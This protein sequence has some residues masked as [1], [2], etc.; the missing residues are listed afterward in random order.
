MSAARGPSMLRIDRFALSIGANVLLA[1]TLVMSRL[2]P[3]TSAPD[4]AAVSASSARGG[5]RLAAIVRH[6]KPANGLSAGQPEWT[7]W[8]GA[9]RASGVS[10]DALATLLTADFDRRWSIYQRS[11]QDR[12]DAGEIDAG[13]MRRRLAQHDREQERELQQALG[14]AEFRAWKKGTLLRDFV[15]AHVTLTAE[16]SDRIF[17]AR[18]ALESNRRALEDAHDDG[19]I[20]T[21]TLAD[22][23]AALGTECAATVNAILGAARVAELSG[24]RDGVDAQARQTLGKFNLSS[25]DLNALADTQRARNTL[26]DQLEKEYVSDPSY[27]ARQLAVDAARDA[28]Y[29]SV[30]GSAR[31]DEWKKSTDPRY[32]TL[33]RYGAALQL[34]DGDIA[35]TYAT[36]QAA[37]QQAERYQLQALSALEAGHSVDWQTVQKQVD[38]TKQTTEQALRERLG[39]Q[40]FEQ[41]FR[42]GI[43]T[44]SP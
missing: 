28:A 25:A 3:S 37:Q 6:D 27:P 12:L 16:E 34:S 44:L 14:P 2:G 41:L 20:D 10:G 43:V 30:L 22:R 17:A 24:I 18:S 35:A 40:R 23:E 9:V 7:K 36:L 33:E 8:I 5:Q 26:Q 38:A 29:A 42:N 39:D 32:Q 31:F 15:S 13:A 19:Q 4:H 21:A 1:A 11:L